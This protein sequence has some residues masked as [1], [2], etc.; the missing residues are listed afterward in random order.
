MT[1]QEGSA[2]PR[3]RVRQVLPVVFAVVLVGL[4]VPVWKWHAWAT[5][6]D[7]P[8]DEIGIDVNLYMPAPLRDWACGR[9]AERFPR[10]VPPYGCG[11][12]QP[13]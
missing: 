13:R 8:Y 3:G 10:S 2:A 7:S 5:S 4:A 9:I 12:R 11:P 1:S 6:G